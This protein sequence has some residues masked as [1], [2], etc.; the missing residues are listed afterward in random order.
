MNTSSTFGLPLAP[1]SRTE[2]CAVPP[3][4]VA[5]AGETVTMMGLG[6]QADPAT[7]VP[8][9]TVLLPITR[10]TATDP[11][12]A[13]KKRTVGYRKSTHVGGDCADEPA[14]SVSDQMPT[15]PVE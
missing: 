2:T 13:M 8:A 1:V 14:G 10:L 6:N 9:G 5:S 7:A 4:A 15:L 3:D 12:P 11:V